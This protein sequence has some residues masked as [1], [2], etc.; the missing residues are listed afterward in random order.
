MLSQCTGHEC[1][2]S[3]AMSMDTAYKTQDPKTV[4]VCDFP[5]ILSLRSANSFSEMQGFNLNTFTS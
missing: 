2:V 1:E 3:T 5:F 4:H